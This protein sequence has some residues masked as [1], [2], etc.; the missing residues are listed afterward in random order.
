M[1]PEYPPPLVDLAPLGWST[2]RI[3]AALAVA[4]PNN[5]RIAQAAQGQLTPDDHVAGFAAW[6]DAQAGDYTPGR[7]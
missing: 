5:R 2:G 7:P 3:A 4:V 1:T 6:C